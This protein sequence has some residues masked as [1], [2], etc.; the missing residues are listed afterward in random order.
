VWNYAS[1]FVL[2]RRRACGTQTRGPSVD[3]NLGDIR[4]VVWR[5]LV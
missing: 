4:S 3:V 2:D 1:D 5:K